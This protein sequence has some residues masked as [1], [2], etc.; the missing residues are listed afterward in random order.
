M[1]DPVGWEATFLPL[2][3]S[4]ATELPVRWL[5]LGR[6]V[7]R[8][9]AGGLAADRSREP[10]PGS[11]MADTCKAG[12]SLPGCLITLVWPECES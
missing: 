11:R 4:G 8:G 7:V 9:R 6:V 5:R 2:V 10:S 12:I 3:V 1:N